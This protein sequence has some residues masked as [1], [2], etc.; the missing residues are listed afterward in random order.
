VKLPVSVTSRGFKH[1]D[2]FFRRS[3]RKTLNY[4]LKMHGEDEKIL[5][6]AKWE[7]VFFRARLCL[8][9]FQTT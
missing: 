3:G 5:I 8:F 1:M 9:L 4:T 2:K 7:F 6:R